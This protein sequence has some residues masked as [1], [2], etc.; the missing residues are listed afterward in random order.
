[1]NIENLAKDLCDGFECQYSEEKVVKAI[2][3]AMESEGLTIEEL[4]N[5]NNEDSGLVYEILSTYYEKDSIEDIELRK[6]LFDLY[7]KAADYIGMNYSN[8][9]QL[10][11]INEAADIVALNLDKMADAPSVSYVLGQCM[12]YIN[13][14]FEEGVNPTLEEYVGMGYE[15]VEKIS[16][17]LGWFFE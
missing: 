4:C 1:M 17:T 8:S 12:C 9:S 5:M 11:I 6:E 15:L 7:Q 10:D 13:K 3:E 2:K 14:D 16:G